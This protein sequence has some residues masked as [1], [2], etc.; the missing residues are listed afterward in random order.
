MSEMAKTLITSME[1]LDEKCKKDGFISVFT[2]I[3]NLC[4]FMPLLTVIMDNY[5]LNICSAQIYM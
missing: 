5:F 3:I 4:L 1:E 2:I